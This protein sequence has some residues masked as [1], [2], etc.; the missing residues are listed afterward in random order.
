MRSAIKRKNTMNAPPSIPAHADRA[1][2]GGLCA[3]GAFFLLSVMMVFAKLLAETHHVIEIAFYRNIVALVPFLFYIYFFKRQK[4]LKTTKP[5]AVLFRSVVGT[6]SLVVTFAAF[7]HLP[8]AEATTLLFCASLLMPALGFFLLKESVGPYRWAAILVG[9]AGIVIM[10]QPGTMVS[11]IGI[12]FGLSAALMHAILGVT[13]R[14]LR[15]EHPITVTFYFI[16]TGALL[17]GLAMPFVANPVSSQEIWLILGAGISGGVAQ[18]LLATAHKFAPPGVV[19]PFNYTGL[20]WATSF[21]LIIWHYVPGW[22]VFAGGGIIIA[23]NLFILW[24]EHRKSKT[25]HKIL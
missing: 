4:L 24:R 8:M 6:V 17:G 7:A 10:V 15:T 3:L 18:T 14:Y 2:L 19:A 13:L 25:P 5:R 9:L 21:D 23:S 16:L 20:I 1:V 22:P 12:V 11:T